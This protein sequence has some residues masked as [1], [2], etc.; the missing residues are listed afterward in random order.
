MRWSTALVTSTLIMTVGYVARAGETRTVEERLIAAEEKNAAQDKRLDSLEARA[1]A[2]QPGTAQETLPTDSQRA[3][4]IAVARALNAQIYAQSTLSS[5]SKITP[6]QQ[7]IWEKI[8]DD[9]EAGKY[10]FTWPRLGAK[11]R[12][13]LITATATFEMRVEMARLRGEYRDET[14][15]R[16]FTRAASAYATALESGKLKD[17]YQAYGAFEAAFPIK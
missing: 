7:I 4:L 3:V 5:G 11:T 16:R 1:V 6:E 10:G 2:T 12:P 14:F 9:V 15:M 17:A 13:A 8:A